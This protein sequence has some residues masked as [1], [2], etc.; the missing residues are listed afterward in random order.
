MGKGGI[1]VSNPNC[2]EVGDVV[3]IAMFRC[4]EDY[5][6]IALPT[7]VDDEWVVRRKETGELYYV[8][9]YT[10]MRLI[11]KAEEK[12]EDAPPRV[13]IEIRGGLPN[14]C[15][16]ETTRGIEVTVRDY[17]CDSAGEDVIKTDAVGDRY[18]EY[19]I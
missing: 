14:L 11:K 16:Q 6:V 8:K 19:T 17:D 5:I 1:V 12:K 7:D 13:V 2:I 4:R 3:E 10:F 15:D 18:I 9:N